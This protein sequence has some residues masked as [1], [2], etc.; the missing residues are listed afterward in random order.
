[1]RK[2]LDTSFCFDYNKTILESALDVYKRQEQR[3]RGDRK[4]KEQ[5]EKLCVLL[6]KISEQR[7]IQ[8]QHK[9]AANPH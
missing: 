3:E 6:R 4:E 1:M 2:G 5:I 7:E 9:A 8:H